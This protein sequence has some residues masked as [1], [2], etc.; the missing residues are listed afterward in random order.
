MKKLILATFAAATLALAFSDQAAAYDGE[1]F[2]VCN[3][4]PN[5]D[6]FLALRSCGS[7]KCKMLRKLGPGT[8]LMTTEPWAENGWREVIVQKNIQDWN[9]Q[10]PSGWVYGKYIC[11]ITYP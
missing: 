8:Y 2:V 10:G 9:Y 3:L 11:R 5:G 4:N 6:N 7:S 1:Q